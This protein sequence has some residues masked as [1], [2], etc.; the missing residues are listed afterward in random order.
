MDSETITA[1][2]IR[3]MFFRVILFVP[4]NF[5]SC[6]P[7]GV[8]AAGVSEYVFLYMPEPGPVPQGQW[9][10]GLSRL[11]RLSACGAA[12]SVVD[13]YHLEVPVERYFQSV[14]QF[15]LILAVV[16][17]YLENFCAGIG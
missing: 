12:V 9:G 6:V 16:F 3:F 1:V 10:C 8:P 13:V 2:T 14:R 5:P 17:L 7:A 11:V 4:E 15:Y